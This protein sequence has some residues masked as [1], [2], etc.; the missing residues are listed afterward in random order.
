[1]AHVNI[2]LYYWI[3]VADVLFVPVKAFYFSVCETGLMP[4]NGAA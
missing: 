2:I 3:I 1:M 4:K